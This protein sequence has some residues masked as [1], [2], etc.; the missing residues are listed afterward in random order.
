MPDEVTA[1]GSGKHPIGEDGNA[2][3]K[4]MGRMPKKARTAYEAIRAAKAEKNYTMGIKLCQEALQDSHLTKSTRAQFLH[5]RSELYHFLSS[6]KASIVD[7]LPDETLVEIFSY[8]ETHDLANIASTCRHWNRIALN[9]ASLWGHHVVLRGT[10][11]RID[12]KWKIIL[13]LTG[14][15]IE[16]IFL[17]F[18]HR[19]FYDQFLKDEE[20]FQ[21]WIKERLLD[22]LPT[23]TLRSFEYS[24]SCEITDMHVWSLVSFCEKLKYLTWRTDAMSDTIA[25]RKVAVDYGIKSTPLSQCRLIEFHFRNQWSSFFDLSYI[26]LLSQVKKLHLETFLPDQRLYEILVASA[27][28]LEELTIFGTSSHIS[29]QYIHELKQREE[30]S[31]E[32]AINMKNLNS[33]CTVYHGDEYLV[34]HYAS[35]HQCNHRILNGIYI[36]YQDVRRFIDQSRISILG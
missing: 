18:S 14:G 3:E 34:S 22:K 9:N 28:T 29:F 23:D 1:A 31:T 35:S 26:D 16:S 21:S 4:P 8:L 24:G 17:D 19:N 33:I 30:K 7:T 13:K 36:E 5:E 12:L 20:I 2:A 32:K 25:D 10:L 27:S 11:K 6:G 15:K